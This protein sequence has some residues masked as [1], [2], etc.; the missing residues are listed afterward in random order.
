MKTWKEFIDQQKQ[1][2][3][4]GLLLAALEEEKQKGRVLPETKNLWQPFIRTP[5]EDVRVVWIVN[6][7]SESAASAGVPYKFDGDPA[8]PIGD[9]KLEMLEDQLGMKI[10]DTTLNSWAKMGVLMISFPLTFRD[11]A[12]EQHRE[13]WYPFIKNM[14]K[15]LSYLEQPIVYLRHEI[16]FS[17][18]E[19]RKPW[20]HLVLEQ[21]SSQFQLAS[22]WLLWNGHVLPD[23]SGLS[24]EEHPLKPD[25]P[26]RRIDRQQE[27][28]A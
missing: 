8:G 24:E 16:T 13:L 15:M 20:H 27:T 10:T 26:V 5:L 28:S 14:L 17:D 7:F 11:G 6:H 12:V 3:Y 4:F 21:E 19:I 18:K 1:E 9:S 22:A 23:W 25:A 2:P